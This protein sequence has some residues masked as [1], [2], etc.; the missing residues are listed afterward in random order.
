V[1]EAELAEW[2]RRARAG[3]YRTQGDAIPNSPGDWDRIVREKDK[4]VRDPGEYVWNG[5]THG[6]PGCIINADTWPTSLEGVPGS[7]GQEGSPEPIR[8]AAFYAMVAQPAEAEAILTAVREVLLE[9]ADSKYNDFAE[10]SRYCSD[11]SGTGYH[12]AY[13]ISAWLT[14]LIFAYDYSQIADPGLW[15]ASDRRRFLDWITAAAQWYMPQVDLRRE[16]LWNPDGTPSLAAETADGRHSR[17]IW[18]GGPQAR[19][20]QLRYNNHVPRLVRIPVLAGILVGDDEMIGYGRRWVREFLKVGVYP[21]GAIADFYRWPG[22]TGHTTGWKYGMENL[23]ATLVIADH[24]ARAGDTSVYEY[25]TTVGTRDTAGSVPNREGTP[26]G[27]KT[28]H[29][30]LRQQVRYVD[31]LSRPVRYGCDGCTDPAKRIRSRDDMV[32]IDRASEWTVLHANVYYRDD[33][34]KAIYMRSLPGTPPLP[35]K[36]RSGQGWIA[37]GE[38]GIYPGVNLMFAQM[39]GEVWPYPRDG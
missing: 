8:D 21:E 39:E 3:P 37:G 10:T 4:F 6:Y 15:S 32:G 22:N 24:I 7:K 5:P 9:T 36:P 30:T 26:G 27:P 25:G 23:G 18:S 20:A 12:P 31:E 38:H 14:K 34:V 1:T 29:T 33:Y 28:L 19:R 2:R 35:E 17:V 16:G 11:Q 13:Q